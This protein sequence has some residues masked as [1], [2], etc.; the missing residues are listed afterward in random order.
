M[1]QVVQGH[2]GSGK[3]PNLRLLGLLGPKKGLVERLN[4]KK[5]EEFERNEKFEG[6]K[7]ECGEE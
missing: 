7:K 1:A 2:L 6:L 4:L 3:K 5:G